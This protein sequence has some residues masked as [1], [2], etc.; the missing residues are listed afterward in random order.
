[1]TWNRTPLPGRCSS[2]R[3]Y[4]SFVLLENNE[5]F[6]SAVLQ[7]LFALWSILKCLWEDYLGYVLYVSCF[8]KKKILLWPHSMLIVSFLEGKYT[9]QNVLAFTECEGALAMLNFI[10]G[11]C[12]LLSLFL[13]TWQ[14]LCLKTAAKELKRAQYLKYCEHLQYCKSHS[15]L[16]W[17]ILDHSLPSP[18]SNSSLLFS[19]FLFLVPLS[20]WF[21]LIGALIVAVLA[22]YQL[23]EFCFSAL[24]CGNCVTLECYRSLRQY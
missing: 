20:N 11:S 21:L 10:W 9:K 7:G 6:T 2:W 16:G 3:S 1:M 23:F 5:L 18:L 13:E 15:D 4:L 17:L 8:K 12:P 24:Y 22:R 19:F 14:C